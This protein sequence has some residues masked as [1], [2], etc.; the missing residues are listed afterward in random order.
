MDGVAGG[1]RAIR[2][3]LRAPVPAGLALVA[4]AGL[5]GIGRHVG[6]GDRLERLYS[7]LVACVI[8]W[9]YVLDRGL[10]VLQQEL[11]LSPRTSCCCI[12]GRR[13]EPQPFG[14]SAPAAVRPQVARPSPGVRAWQV[15]EPPQTRWTPVPAA[16]P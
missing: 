16:A 11:P 12:S 2:P 7:R 8:S 3:R 9:H 14:R 13:S 5:T 6:P 10:G 15:R 1:G 4:A